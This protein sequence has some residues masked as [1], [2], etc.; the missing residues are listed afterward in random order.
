MRKLFL[1]IIPF[2]IFCLFF[3]RSY[4]QATFQSIAAGPWNAASTW[5]IISGSDA[6]GIPDGN[7]DAI[8]LSGHNITTSSSPQSNINNLTI[9]AGGTLTMGSGN[10]LGVNRLLTNNGTFAGTGNMGLRR[11]DGGIIITGTGTWTNTGNIWFNNTTATTQIIDA[12]VVMVKTAG[13]LF[14]NN[15]SGS[16]NNEWVTNNGSITLNNGT[17]NLQSPSNSGQWTQGA[18]STL[19]I[20]SLPMNGSGAIFETSALTNTVIYTGGNYAIK[21]PSLSQ[22]YNLTI[23]AGS[24]TFAFNLTVNDLTANAGAV[25]NRTASQNIT[26]S[27]NWTANGNILTVQGGGTVTFNGTNPQSIGGAASLQWF[28]SLTIA[29]T[30]TVTLLRSAQLNNLL[31]V[32]SGTFDLGSFTCNRG[33]AGGTLTVSNGATLK[34]GGTNTFPANYTTNTLGVSSTVEYNGSGAQTVGAQTYGNLTINNASG[35]SSSGAVTIAGATTALTSGTYTT[36]SSLTFNGTA[37]QTIAGSGSITCSSTGTITM[38]NAAGVTTSSA[39]TISGTITVSAGT[40]TTGATTITLTSTAGN[41]GRIGNSAGS[42]SGSDWRAQRFIPASTV[43]WD[44]ISTPISGNTLSDWDNELYMSIASGCPD[45]TAGGWYS[46]YQF[47]AATQS[48][49]PITTCSPALSTAGGYEIWLG[50][51]ISTLSATTMDSRGTPN[52]GDQAASLASGSGNWSLIGNPYAS[53]IDWAL[54][55]ADASGLSNFFQIFDESINDYAVYDPSGGSTG[56]LA[57]SGG[58]MSSTQGFWVQNSGASPSLTFKE[59]HKSATNRPLVREANSLPHNMLKMR[60]YSHTM[61]NAGESVIKINDDGMESF[62]L[63]TDVSFMRSRDTLT[64]SLTPVTTDGI[65][66]RIKT[67]P[68]K[69]SL[70]I[71]LAVQ[72]YIPGNYF[73]DFNGINT[74]FKYNCISLEDKETGATIPL[75]SEKTYSFSQPDISKERTFILHL[76]NSC[77]EQTPFANT[78]RVYAV[79]EGVALNFNFEELTSAKISV[80]NVLGENI[81]NQNVRTEKEVITIP[82]S[83]ASQIYFVKVT[84]LSGT[85]TYKVFH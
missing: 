72:V 58:I 60:L 35:V 19:S 77:N 16:N 6:D 22:Y 85:T 66:T 82:L 84:T 51:T 67:I 18:G 52:V 2:L 26:I 80:Y 3:V 64:P 1:Q 12:N 29:S 68:Q 49:V 8:I 59:S 41:T 55:F 79:Q 83:G 75:T 63:S 27:G 76:K 53:G 69:S 57:S 45:G 44:D 38:S 78:V 23:A 17:I 48:F 5:T 15:G 36:N 65:K 37:A 43:N 70:S 71:P 9:D 81:V 7:D 73:I 62:N 30:S 50:T 46:V 25:L 11:T 74:V 39:M 28:P 40:F 32:S 61:K 56:Q 31:T 14:L 21:Q 10:S 47:A 42:I 54:V 20:N 24:K 34:I 13:S 4:S 33:A